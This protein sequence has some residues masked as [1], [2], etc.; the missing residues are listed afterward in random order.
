MKKVIL[1]IGVLVSTLSVSKAQLALGADLSYNQYFG[2]GVGGIMGIGAIG[3]YGIKEGK[4]SIRGSFNYLFPKSYSGSVDANALS[5]ATSPQYISVSYTD[6]LHIMS[7]NADFKKY[8]G[9]G[10]FKEG[11]FYGGLGAGLTFASTA[12]TYGSYDHNEYTVND[13]GSTQSYTQWMIRGVIGYEKTF[14][15]GGIFGE[16]VLN[17]P[18]THV[19]GNAVEI[20]IPASVTVQV[21]YKYLFGGK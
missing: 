13:D 12:I 21:G 16:A 2:A 4:Y 3:D 9:E 14:D 11:G 19:N 15:F 1:V 5:S 10:E 18:A 17:V 8:F 7:F 6:K 20:N